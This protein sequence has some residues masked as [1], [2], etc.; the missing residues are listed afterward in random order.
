MALTT[1]AN[2]TELAGYIARGATLVAFWTPWS[3]PC[4]TQL[5]IL[6]QVEQEIGHAVAF[7]RVD[8]EA[9]G[10]LASQYRIEGLPT[11]ILFRNG[12]IDRRFVGVQTS[13]DLLAAI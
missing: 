2:E 9:Q 3:E 13:E 7:C 1:I 8:V 11:L 12:V 4:Q 10:G 6:E 5:T